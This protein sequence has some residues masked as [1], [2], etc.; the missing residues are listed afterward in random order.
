M[1]NTKTVF[2]LQKTTL[3]RTSEY[4]ELFF[5]YLISHSALLTGKWRHSYTTIQKIQKGG[6]VLQVRNLKAK[7]DCDTISQPLRT[8]TQVPKKRI[9]KNHKFFHIPDMKWGKQTKKTLKM[10]KNVTSKGKQYLCASHWS[11]FASRKLIHKDGITTSR[12]MKIALN[13]IRH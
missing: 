5:S 2:G 3:P 6:A 13:C 8:V 12:I 4:A 9:V 7:H 10:G 11:S 1:T